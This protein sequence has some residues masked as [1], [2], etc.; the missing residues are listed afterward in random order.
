MKVGG[1]FN[2]KGSFPA[3]YLSL[4]K[5]TA[6]AEAEYWQ[7]TSGIDDFITQTQVVA[8]VR[9][10]LQRILDLTDDV[11]RSRLQLSAEDLIGNWKAQQ[12]AGHEAL[13][14]AI[15]RMARSAGFEAILTMS[16]RRKDGCNLVLFPDRMLAGSTLVLG[17]LLD[18]P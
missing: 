6:L 8:G 4:D 1:R 7:K 9:V 16:A 18:S 17:R 14:Q 3:T 13:T 12:K 5:A 2:V 10:N 11:T 15:G